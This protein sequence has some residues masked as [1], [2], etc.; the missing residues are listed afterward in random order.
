MGMGI[1]N[2]IL[3]AIQGL[4]YYMR[5]QNTFEKVKKKNILILID[6]VGIGGYSIAA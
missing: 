5:P 1:K 3:I 6:S 4:A 2:K